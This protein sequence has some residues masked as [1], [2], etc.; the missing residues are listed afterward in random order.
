MDGL[1]AELHQS[2]QGLWE[3]GR[4]AWPGL[5]LSLATFGACLRER[6]GDQ[7]TAQE[8]ARLQGADLFLACACLRRLPGAV[9][10]FDAA[11]WPE[12]SRF[13]RTLQPQASQLEETRQAL[14]VKLFVPADATA[15]PKIAEYSGRGPLRAW[16]RMAVKRM[17]LNEIRDQKWVTGLGDSY[18]ERAVRSTRNLELSIIRGQ[19]EADFVAALREALAGLPPEQRLV[20]QFHYRDGL[21]MDALAAVLHTSRASAHRRL[22]LARTELARLVREELREGLVGPA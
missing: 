22:D 19:H 10:S 2:I 6:A 18:A 3:Q 14:L 9:D 4:A 1:D 5:A 7:L 20:L 21:K 15:Q 8:L 17:A 11:F 16:L 12:L 13:L